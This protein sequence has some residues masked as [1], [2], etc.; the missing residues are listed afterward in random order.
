MANTASIIDL[1]MES[2]AGLIEYVRARTD[3]KATL[4]STRYSMEEIDKDYY[5]TRDLTEEHVKA[6]IANRRGDTSKYQN[7]T[8]PIVY[9]Q[10]ES[11]VAYQASV[12]LTGE[13]MFGIVAQAKYIDAAMQMEAII[14][15]QATMFSWKKELIK[16]F[17][18]CG[19][20]NL[21]AVEVAWKDITT[22]ALD[23]DPTFHDTEGKPRNVV[24]SG[25]CLKAMDLYNTFWD[26]TCAAEDVPAYAEYAGY[27]EMVTRTKLKQM[28]AELPEYIVNNAEV[29]FESPTP[30]DI[31][32][33]PRVNPFALLDVD[34]NTNS[35]EPDWAAWAQLSKG[36]ND[37]AYKSKY[38]VTHI[39]VRIIPS[40]FSIKV[41]RKNTPQIWKLMVVNMSVII[42]AE[43]QTNAHN[44]IPI[45]FAAP[46]D[47]GLKYQTKGIAENVQELQHIGSA[48]M[49]SFIAGRRRAISDRGIYNP[50]Y[51]N[52]ADINSDNPAAKIPLKPTA[53]QSPV[54]DQIY[55]QIPFSDDQGPTAL[56][57]VSLMMGFADSITGQ[58][59][60]Q[61]GQFVKGNKTL[62]EYADVM[63]NANARAQL[64]AITLEEQAFAPIKHI[65]KINVLQYQAAGELY[66]EG[67]DRTVQIDPVV[68]RNSVFS[69]KVSD[70]LIPKDKL[71]SAEEW[72]TAMQVI[73][74]SPQI[75]SE[76]NI[77]A[78]FSYLMRLQGADIKQFE[79]EPEVRMF[80]QAMA[81]WNQAVALITDTNA[82]LSG[83]EGYKPQALP[84]QPK[85]ADYGLGQDG[86]PMEERE[87]AT[88][89]SIL[90]QM[91]TSGQQP[92]N[93][94]GEAA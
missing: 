81:Q 80:E 54:M 87:D 64:A 73:G 52:K 82:K 4:Y 7:Q 22:A 86:K 67:K 28:L 68:L 6:R 88:P 33:V 26:T 49:N 5:R 27:H 35:A 46:N 36:R 11:F 76:Y 25:N 62:H 47:D 44:L 37:I 34:P 48:L 30:W 40:E 39:Y 56:N 92:T 90:S 45:I 77:S 74:S 41:P 16:F 71:I 38:L 57:G 1:S 20:Y 59:K 32:H 94:E 60:A 24:Y 15:D 9:P 91:M 72:T 18:S 79:K 42:Y 3:T 78:M 17:R 31:Y 50:L 13:P 69:F 58:N 83:K 21:G 8:V 93:Q 89:P 55:H 51:I 2:Q 53:Y 66:H 14:S 43:R 23:T 29:A 84:P 65:L 85:P 10:V 63:G 19:K 75:G 61:Q 12:F 70:G